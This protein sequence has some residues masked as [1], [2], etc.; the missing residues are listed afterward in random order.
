MTT[1]TREVTVRLLQPHPHQALFVDSQAKRI[2]VRAGRRGGKTTG[3]ATR[4]V[5]RFLEGRRQLY[6]TPTA[7]QL[8]AYWFEVKRALAEPIAAK[9]F[10]I[11]ETEH[12]VEKTGTKQRIRAKTA[13]NADT[14]RGDYADDLYLDEW[15]LMNEDAWEVVGAPML[16]DNNGDAC[17]IY[18]PPSLHSA[19]VSKAKDPR[20]AAKMFAAALEDKSGRWAA[21]HFT[22]RD[23]P[24]ISGAALTELTADMS[25]DAY[26][27]EILAED[28]DATLDLLVYSMFDERTQV[29]DPISLP[30]EWP[31]YVGH[32]FGQSNP[33]AIFLAQDPNGNVFI[34][35]EYLPGPGR[36]VLQHTEEWKQNTI[37]LNVLKRKGGNTN[38]QD[39]IRQGYS[40]N[41]WHIVAP[42]WTKPAKQIEVVQGM[43]ERNR[44][45]VF[46]TCHAFLEEI[47]NCLW[48]TDRDGVRLD[49]IR[50]EPTYHLLAAL[51]YVGSDFTPET[52]DG[53]TQHYVVTRYGH[54]GNTKRTMLR[55][56][57]A[58]RRMMQR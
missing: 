17:F 16:L 32:D 9:A 37:G 7:D 13:W 56:M 14:L 57:G 6:A 18:T 43:M 25:R 27:R 21:F 26:R 1:A 28:D 38:N 30:K 31:R 12:V 42:K 4:S 46:K 39:E 3:M 44:V 23:N 36:S 51:R 34:Y 2:I 11:N 24:Y 58:R 19:G 54:S 22:S 45:F 10:Y 50:R 8:D 53:E 52:V 41:G 20:H 49:K 29:I 40:A 15:Q 5:R 33:A 47:R 35:D 48:E 55:T